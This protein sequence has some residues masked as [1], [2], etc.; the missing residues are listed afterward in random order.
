[1]LPPSQQ[2]RPPPIRQTLTPANGQGTEA[3]TVKG[4]TVHQ[5]HPFAGQ[6]GGKLRDELSRIYDSDRDPE[7]TAAKALCRPLMSAIRKAAGLR[8]VCDK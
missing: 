2:P 8:N 1:M 4:Q 7:K 3:F 6:F 5:H